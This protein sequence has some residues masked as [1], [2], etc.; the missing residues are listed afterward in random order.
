MALTALK[1]VIEG[2]GAHL[3]QG[4]WYFLCTLEIS[5]HGDDVRYE[6]RWY[7][8]AKCDLERIQSELRHAGIGELEKVAVSPS[9]SA[10]A[11]LQFGSHGKGLV[12][13]EV[14]TYS[15]IMAEPEHVIEA[16]RS[17]II[18]DDSKVPVPHHDQHIVTHRS[19][20]YFEPYIVCI[21]SKDASEQ[22]IL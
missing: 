21:H 2:V 11:M 1:K 3:S 9:A 18:S 17:V 12:P 10:T 7:D 22:M 5:L 6:A 13:S 20:Y 16:N 15:K 4:I 14:D 8:F 19:F